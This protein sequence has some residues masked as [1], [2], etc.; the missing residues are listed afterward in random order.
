[1]T[2]SG[3]V[4]S[5]I[6]KAYNAPPSIVSKPSG[7][8]IDVMDEQPAKHPEPNVFNVFGSVTFSNVKIELK[9][10]E[11]IEEMP[12]P[13]IRFFTSLSLHGYSPG[14]QVAMAPVPKIVNVAPDITAVT[15]LAV[16]APTSQGLSADPSC[17]V[18]A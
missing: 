9:A 10:S 13:M 8:E 18:S 1:M 16:S 7:S 11:G 15:L 12:E 2:L 17:T 3:T 6:P 4:I 14:S 5:V